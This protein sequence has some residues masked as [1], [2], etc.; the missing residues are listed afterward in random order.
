MVVVMTDSFFRD[1][2]GKK[3]LMISLKNAEGLL[4]EVT[5]EQ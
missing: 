2:M 1:K 4:I 5:V 3:G